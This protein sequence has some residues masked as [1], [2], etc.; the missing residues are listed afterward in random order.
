MLYLPASMAD[1][2]ETP[3]IEA[4]LSLDHMKDEAGQECLLLTLPLESNNT[5]RLPMTVPIAMRIWALL[6]KVRQDNGWSAP[7]TPIS[8]DQAK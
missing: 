3:D 5:V 8:T 7:S 4:V 1:S 2:T 6:D